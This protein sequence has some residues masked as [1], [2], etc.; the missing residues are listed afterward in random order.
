MRR[1]FISISFII[2]LLTGCTR[3]TANTTQAPPEKI[4][5]P[6]GYIPNVQYAPFYMA[7]EKGYFADANLDVTF[8]YSLETN[9]MA[10]V[11]ADE[12]PFAVV[13]GEQVLMAR[14][15]GLPV[16]YV[17][18][19]WQDYPVGLAALKETGIRT[20][21]DMRDKKIG[22]PGLFGASYVGFHA[23]LQA[24]GLQE[25][26]LILDSIGFSQVEALLAGQEDAIVIYANNEP[27]Q[28]EALGYEIDLIKVSDYAKMA[29]NGI[30]TNESVLAENPELAQRLVS[31]LLKGLADVLEDPEEAF[32]VCKKHVD[33]LASLPA[34]Q[35]EIQRKVLEASME[36]W[37]AD[38]LGYSDPEAWETMQDVLLGMGFLTEKQD[39][40]KAYTNQFIP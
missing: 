35:Q 29:S 20:P 32:D 38:R 22:I 30:I 8:D 4:R 31:V 28:L 16:V 15:Q 10:L 3:S 1:F 33:G 34:D 27:I 23:L 21:E 11:G 19:M 25:T 26:D 5:L 24:G 37:K 7:V 17:A 6:M 13:S 12:V 40:S 18:A 36:Y 39:L 14:G 9:G 2:F